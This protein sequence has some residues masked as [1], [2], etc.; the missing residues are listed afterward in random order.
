MGWVP[1]PHPPPALQSSGPGASSGP[2]GDHSELLV[3][4]ASLE[5]ENQ[6]LK[7]GEAPGLAGQG[8]SLRVPAV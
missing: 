7:G 6:S 2:G 5:V 8:R 3:R 4:I 1:G